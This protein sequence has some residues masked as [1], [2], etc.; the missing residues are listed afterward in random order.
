MML[1]RLICYAYA[2]AMAVA[3]IIGIVMQ[4]AMLLY[5]AV[6]FGLAVW[7]PGGKRF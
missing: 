3:T 5:F 4:P 6:I 1:Y 7:L 2:I